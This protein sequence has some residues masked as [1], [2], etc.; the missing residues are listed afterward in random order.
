MNLVKSIA[1][2]ISGVLI[3]GSII[4]AKVGLINSSIS[5][6]AAT[7][8]SGIGVGAG[9]GLFVF[10]GVSNASFIESI[11]TGIFIGIVAAFTFYTYNRMR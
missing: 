2:V 6:R 7:I 3:A 5:F 9:T 10:F 4:L 11:V 1:L 8:L